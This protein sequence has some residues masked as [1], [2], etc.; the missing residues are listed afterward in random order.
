M[1]I[2]EY[3]FRKITSLQSKNDNTYIPFILELLRFTFSGT[4]LE[5]LYGKLDQIN[6]TYTHTHTH[7]LKIYTCTSILG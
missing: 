1:T 7:L 4:Y 5:A 3:F 2:M 6:M